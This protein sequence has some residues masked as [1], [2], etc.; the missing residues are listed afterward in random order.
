MTTHVYAPRTVLVRH[1]VAKLSS[2]LDALRVLNSY[3]SSKTDLAEVVRNL[4]R[5]VAVTF[6]A[7]GTHRAASRCRRDHC[8]NR[9]LGEIGLCPPDRFSMPFRCI[10]ALDAI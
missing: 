5:P 7:A 1:Y 10:I 4:H 9:P 3:K 6:L 8:C 2:A